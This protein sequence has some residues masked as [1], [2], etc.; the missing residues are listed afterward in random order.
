[1]MPADNMS[2]WRRDI[3]QCLREAGPTVVRYPGGCFT[4]FYNWRSSVGP[5]ERREPQDSFYWGGIEEND[6]GLGEFLT[7]AELCGFEGQICFIMMTSTP[8]D[9]RCMV[10]YL[11]APSDVGYGRLR[12]ADGREA[13][14][15]VRL[16]ECDNEPNRK[17]SAE[18][19]AQQCVDFAREMREVTP[20]AEF[21][22]A[23]YAYKPDALPA[24]LEIAGG[25]INYVIHRAGHPEFVA[26]ILPMIRE[27]NAKTGRNIR[28]VNTEWLP[29]CGSPEPF[30]E[31]GIETDFRWR[32][33]ITND[34]DKV[35]SRHQ[36]SWNYA[37]NG[38]RRILDYISYGGEF[39]LANF[40][41]MA[42]TWGQN[43][44]EGSKDGAWL[45]CM[46]QIFAFFHRN[47]KPCTAALTDTGDPLIYALLVKDSDGDGLYDGLYIVNCGGTDK[48]VTLP[49][50]FTVED[51]LTAPRRSAHITEH[52]CPVTRVMPEVKNNITTI[53]ALSVL[54]FKAK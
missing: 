36:I 40:N 48:E 7:L 12:K 4:S 49:G 47:Y 1:M 30:D 17:W 14:W 28:L 41:N 25:D 35:L 33:R 26:R 44:V 39:A 51:G 24:I 5:R 13:P 21:M 45:S 10:E 54:Y 38:A 29:S 50:A 42:N 3:V 32:G 8:F 20:E 34:Y 18:Q 6:V 2:G 22:L 43:I 37:V 15:N 9:A 19:Y 52:D 53:P 16:F 23:A 11:N 46:G 27:Y 31:P